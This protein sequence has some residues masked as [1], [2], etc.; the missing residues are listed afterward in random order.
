MKG[1]AVFD[2]PFSGTLTGMGANVSHDLWTFE[3]RQGQKITIDNNSVGK[4]IAVYDPAG[5]L[6]EESEFNI[7]PVTLPTDGTYT[8]IVRANIVGRY[9]L[10]LREVTD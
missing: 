1:E 7:G 5:N 9:V 3:G 4:V 2:V 10:T 6:L 8:L